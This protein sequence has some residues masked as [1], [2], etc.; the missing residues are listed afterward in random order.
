MADI[1]FSFSDDQ[2]E[3]VFSASTPKGE[4][5]MEA[6]ELSVPTSEAKEFREDAEAAGLTVEKF[7]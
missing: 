3:V 2:T 6:S 7:P 5:W 4:E 1:T